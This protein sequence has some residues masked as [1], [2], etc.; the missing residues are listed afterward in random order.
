MNA[1]GPVLHIDVKKLGRISRLGWRVTGGKPSRGVRGYHRKAHKLG[2]EFVHVC[3]DDARHAW[4][5]S[6]S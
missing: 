6:R 2:W 4:P 1:A 3:V 5:T